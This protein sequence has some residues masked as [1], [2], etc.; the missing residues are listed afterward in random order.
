M[1]SDHKSVWQVITLSDTFIFLKKSK[2]N[3]IVNNHGNYYNIISANRVDIK[4]LEKLTTSLFTIENPLTSL[5][6]LFL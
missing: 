6:V 4:L 5:L 2:E 1:D 3:L